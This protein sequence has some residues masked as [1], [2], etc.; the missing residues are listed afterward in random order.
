MKNRRGI[1]LLITLTLISFAFLAGFFA[2]SNRRGF[3]LCIPSASVESVAY[4]AESTA[5]TPADRININT[6][7][8]EQLQTRPG[9]GPALAQRI[10]NY[11]TQNGPFATVAELTKVEGIGSNRLKNLL[12]YITLGG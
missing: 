11:R 10:L 4:T 12:D 2:A 9:I 3:S 6:P 8:E 5:N 7:T 1:Y